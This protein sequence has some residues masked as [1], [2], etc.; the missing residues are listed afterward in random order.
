M[1]QY[2]ELRGG[3]VT[4][5]WG[6]SAMWR[7]TVS[8]L[9]LAVPQWEE[10][11]IPTPT[12]GW[13]FLH[14]QKSIPSPARLWLTI[15]AAGNLHRNESQFSPFSRELD[16]GL[17]ELQKSRDAEPRIRDDCSVRGHSPHYYSH[18]WN[19]LQVQ[20]SSGSRIH[21]EGLTE[22]CYPHCYSLLPAKE[23]DTI[24]QRERHVGTVQR[25]TS[26]TAFLAP[27]CD[28]THRAQSTWEAH[29]SLFLLGVIKQA[30]LT[31]VQW[32][33]HTGFCHQ[34]LICG[35]WPWFL[36]QHS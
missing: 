6:P 27:V 1:P 2:T 29:P 34:F 35:L 23:A 11:T 24:S 9:G 32:R 17:N 8:H 31:A 28:N 22:N 30:R 15:P 33:S 12:V 36:T 10:L 18:I 25:R 26:C 14:V 5:Y 21:L 16:T 4:G 7:E 20:K 3:E 13:D 19:Q